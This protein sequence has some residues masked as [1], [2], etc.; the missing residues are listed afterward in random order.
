MFGGL[1]ELVRTTAVTAGGPL[2]GWSAR[3][4]APNP[5]RP[6][7]VRGYLAQSPLLSQFPAIMGAVQ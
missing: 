7:R 3:P 4:A 6:G 2:M 1:H 5:R